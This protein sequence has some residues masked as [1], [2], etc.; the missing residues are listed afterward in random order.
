MTQ[1]SDNNAEINKNNDNTNNNNNIDKT[2]D[3]KIMTTTIVRRM[4][5]NDC[6]YQ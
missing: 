5:K 6:Q 1:D 4:Q 3:N 2:N